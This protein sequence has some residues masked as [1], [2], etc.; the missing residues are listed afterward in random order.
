MA[1]GLADK[2]N[3]GKHRG[4]TI[5]DVIENDPT[6]IEWMLDTVEAVEFEDTA[7]KEYESAIDEY[8]R[9]DESKYP[10]PHYSDW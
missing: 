1:Y 7:M 6:Y 5:K 4:K 8:Y 2:I 3:F 9:N 10:S